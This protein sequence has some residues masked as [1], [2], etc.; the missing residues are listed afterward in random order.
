[1]KTYIL[2]ETT[3]LIIWFN[4][5]MSVCLVGDKTDEPTRGALVDPDLYRIEAGID[6]Y[7]K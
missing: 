2:C 4:S 7:I 1:M 6:D 3:A 5:S